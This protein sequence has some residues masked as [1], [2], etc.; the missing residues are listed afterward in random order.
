[1]KKL[2]LTIAALFCMASVVQA[3]PTLQLDIGGGV[4]DPVSETTIA[5]SS[6]FTLYALLNDSSIKDDTFYLSAAV[7]P[8]QTT[9]A[10]LGSFTFNGAPVAVTGDMIYGT[11]PVA[12]TDTHDLQSHGVFETYFKEFAFTFA[13][14]SQ[15]TPYD[16]Q[17]GEPVL[18]GSGMYYMPFTV[19]VSGLTS[20]D[21]IIH[22]DLYSQ[23]YRNGD[24]T[25]LLE[26]APFS[27][28][29]QSPPV[30]EPGTIVLFGAG[31]L[32][33]AIYGKRRMNN[34]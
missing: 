29:A 32:G 31:L 15:L 20:L 5:S 3:Y 10:N 28:D 26:F 25:A 18:S 13:T 33:L 30:P 14:A 34:A 11:P 2:I 12:L 23:K 9:G 6:S 4:Y 27:H 1:M 8:Q 16:A 7:I 24:S 19:D 17:Y 21:T 22:F